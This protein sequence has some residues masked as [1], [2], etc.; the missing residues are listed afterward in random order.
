MLK[1]CFVCRKEIP[2]ESPMLIP[3]VYPK[4]VATPFFAF[5]VCCSETC[6]IK[7]QDLDMDDCIKH[8]GIKQEGEI[9]EQI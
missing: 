1:K 9:D 7:L 5:P 6:A 8:H 2:E 3:T 4:A